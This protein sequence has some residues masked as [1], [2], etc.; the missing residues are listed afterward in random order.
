MG[1][2]IQFHWM[3][4]ASVAVTGIQNVDNPSAGA[5]ACN[6]RVPAA[7]RQYLLREITVSVVV[8]DREAPEP[9]LFLLANDQIERAVI[10]H[11]SGAYIV[12]PGVSGIDNMLDPDAVPAIHRSLPP[13]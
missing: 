10:I 1:I 11:V 9:R 3:Q 13:V 12:Y 5:I 8:E 2:Q 4:R 7:A 6:L